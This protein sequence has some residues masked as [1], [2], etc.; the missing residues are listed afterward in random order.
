MLSVRRLTPTCACWVAQVVAL[1]LQLGAFVDT[2]SASCGR[3]ALMRAAAEG[4]LESLGLL[5]EAKA[6]VQLRSLD[7]STAL[8]YAAGAGEEDAVIQLVKVRSGLPA[9]LID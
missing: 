4:Q 6:D 7:D 2:V 8:H 9:C 3:T 1:L 5:I